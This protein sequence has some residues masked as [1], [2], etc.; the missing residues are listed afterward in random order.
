MAASSKGLLHGSFSI[1]PN[2]LL[3]LKGVVHINYNVLQSLYPCPTGVNGG[4][5]I[6]WH[7]RLIISDVIKIRI[8][9]L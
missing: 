7:V 6:L 2:Y 1:V 8:D 9:F 5:K 4:V 3:F